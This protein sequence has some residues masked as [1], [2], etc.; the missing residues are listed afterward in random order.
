MKLVALEQLHLGDLRDG[1][2]DLLR[3]AGGGAA[4]AEH[5][6][7]ETAL[8]LPL[9]ENL[10]HVGVA[11]GD[12]ERREAGAIHV[13]DQ[14]QAARLE[15]I[16]RDLGKPGG[17]RTR[18]G[19]VAPDDAG[20]LSGRVAHDRA[21]DE[22]GGVGRARLDPE[23]LQ[24]AAVQEDL[25]VGLLQR[26]RIV[27]RDAIQFLAR[28]R[29]PI[30]RELLMR[31]AT[32]VEDPSAR[33]FRLRAG[34]QH[35]DRLLARLDPVEAQLQLAR[36][37]PARSRCMW[38]SISPGMTA[39]PP[40]V[41]PSWCSAPRA[42]RS[43]GWCRPPRCGRPDRHRL[44]DREAIVD[45]DDLP[46]RQHQI[47]SRAGRR[48]LRGARRLKCAGGHTQRNRD[49]TSRSLSCHRPRSEVRV[50]PDAMPAPLS[51]P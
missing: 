19:N 15:L 40:Q 22:V 47:G 13:L 36:C 33:P 14:R 24:G 26:D 12:A 45:G 18:G 2:L 32:D 1:P 27:R 21:L 38:L 9:L 28:E 39:L 3:A 30:V 31:P 48:V 34:A 11:A 17:H 6:D 37:S 5:P 46:V 7:V 35:L 41:D 44:R 10:Q 4:D 29:L 49:R 8:R 20:R 50:K 43:P 25:V 42:G 51:R 23:R 16:R